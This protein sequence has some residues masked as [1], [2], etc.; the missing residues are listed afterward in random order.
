MSI[1]DS[2]EAGKGDVRRT[3]LEFMLGFACCHLGLSEN[4]IPVKSIGFSSFFLVHWPFGGNFFLQFSIT[5]ICIG[6]VQIKFD[7]EADGL[8]RQRL[9]TLEAR[10]GVG[11]FLVLTEQID[12]LTQ[13]LPD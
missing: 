6:R 3:L 11:Q 5:P 1:I 8:L 7:G 9:A 10:Q 2:D 13:G 12:C 4:W